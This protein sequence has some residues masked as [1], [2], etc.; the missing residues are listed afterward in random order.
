MDA[1]QEG[2]RLSKLAR[3]RICEPKFGGMRRLLGPL[4]ALL[5]F[6]VQFDASRDAAIYSLHLLL[7]CLS[8]SHHLNTSIFPQHRHNPL[9]RTGIDLYQGHTT[10]PPPRASLHDRRTRTDATGRLQD[11]IVKPDAVNE[12]N[13]QGESRLCLSTQPSSTAVETIRWRF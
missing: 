12:V 9:R 7:R 4:R 6:P 3:W 13:L 2:V 11:L 8:S 1:G 5:P 10:L